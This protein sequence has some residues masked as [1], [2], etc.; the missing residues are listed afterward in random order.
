MAVY[1]EAGVYEVEAVEHA[2]TK[3]QSGNPMIEVQVRPIDRI[4][5]AGMDGE[6]REPVDQNERVGYLRF[7]MPQGDDE[8]SEKTRAITMKKL[9]TAGWTGTDFSTFSLD[10]PFQCECKHGTYQDKP[11]EDWDV[12]QGR[13]SA[14]HQPE[15]ASEMNSIMDKMLKSETLM[16]AAPEKTVDVSQP[17]GTAPTTGGAASDDIPFARWEGSL[18]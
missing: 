12:F 7:V 11:K 4:F 10:Q 5:Q 18:V 17:A 6:Y 8:K 16:A 1:Y 9:R 2:F 15:L 14:E 3:A 13:R